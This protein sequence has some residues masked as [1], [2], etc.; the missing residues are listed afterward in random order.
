MQQTDRQTD[1]QKKK[2]NLQFPV[3]HRP[4]NHDFVTKMKEK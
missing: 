4:M 2:T 3:W 1:R